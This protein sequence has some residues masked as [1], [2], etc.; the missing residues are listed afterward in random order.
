[1]GFLERYSGK[2][3]PPDEVDEVVKR[4][5]D[6]ADTALVGLFDKFRPFKIHNSQLRNLRMRLSDVHTRTQIEHKK[7]SS[8]IFEGSGV[9]AVFESHFKRLTDEKNERYEGDKQ[10]LI[11]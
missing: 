3:L 11:I 10:S 7:A 2:S 5:G 4:L 8:L 9:R 6:L 1:M